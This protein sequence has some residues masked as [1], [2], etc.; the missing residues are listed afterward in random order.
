MNESETKLNS[1][2]QAKRVRDQ[3]E[4]K[5]KANSHHRKR[6]EIEA[7]GRVKCCY[8]KQAETLPSYV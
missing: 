6:I 3:P 2:E 5:R 1:I 7:V 8:A 4:A